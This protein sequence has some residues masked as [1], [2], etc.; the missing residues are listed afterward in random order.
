MGINNL[1]PFFPRSVTIS[2]YL[3]CMAAF[4]SSNSAACLS[5]LADYTSALLL[6]IVASLILLCFAAAD[7]AFN[8]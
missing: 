7:K 5:K 6:I 4:V 3:I 1:A 2:K 8:V